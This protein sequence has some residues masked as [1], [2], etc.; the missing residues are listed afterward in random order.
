MTSLLGQ[1][2]QKLLD[3]WATL[4]AVPGFLYL[5][6][7]TVAAVLG[8]DHAVSHRTLVRRVTELAAD[9]VLRSAGGT[10]LV[11]SAVFAGSVAAG[12]AAAAG[13]RFVERLWTLPGNRAP[14]RW[15]A[16][17][18]RELSRRHKAVA[19]SEAAS[20]AEVR[21][22]IA[23]ADRICLVEAARPTW[24]GDRL[25]ACQVR[26]ARAYRL[27]LPVVWPR[28]WL[29]IPDAARTELGAARD[30]FSAAARLTA[31]AVLY[32]ALGVLW[33]PAALVAV[34]TGIAAGVRAREATENLAGLVESTVDLY[35]RDLA[36]QLGEHPGE[37]SLPAAAGTRLTTLMRKSRWDPQSPLAD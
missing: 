24:I 35:G 17:R 26:I 33:W 25:R 9:P 14:A 20:A 37:G 32:L 7:L 8:Q 13:G 28:L 29:I 27:D 4:L 1:F 2:G 36:V 34:V 15:L 21:A 18:R 23:R 5:A 19:D 30:A 10:A 6:A 31:W 22:A 12:L 3:R 11:I 16:E